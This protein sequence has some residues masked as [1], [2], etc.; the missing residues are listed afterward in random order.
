MIGRGP[1]LYIDICEIEPSRHFLEASKGG[2]NTTEE[3]SSTNGCESV[4]STSRRAKSTCGG[5]SLSRV[6][7][8]G[9]G[10]A[11]SEGYVRGSGGDTGEG[12]RSARRRGSLGSIVGDG[13]VG[14]EH[15]VNDVDDTAAEQDVGVDDLGAV[16][17]VA[18]VDVLNSQVATNEGGNSCLARGDISAVEDAVVHHVVAQDGDELSDRGIG[19]CITNGLESIVVRSK[20]SDVVQA[21]EGG[22]QVEF[23]SRTSK[24]SQVGVCQGRSEVSGDG[25]GAVDDVDHT[26]GEVEI[27]AGDRNIVLQAAEEVGCAI[28]QNTFHNLSSSDVGEGRVGQVSVR[29]GRGNIVEIA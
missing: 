23:L 12:L 16:D 29:E 18:A 10:L 19:E 9:C 4:G 11:R 3:S 28:L 5:T 24:R 26:S 15:S 20:N 2:T 13:V 22:C 7:R 8:A 21:A 14:V 25:K 6:G 17:I 27:G 1:D